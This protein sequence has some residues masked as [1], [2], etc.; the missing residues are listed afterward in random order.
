MHEEEIPFEKYDPELYW[1]DPAPLD[2]PPDIPILSVLLQKSLLRHWPDDPALA[3]FAEL[4]L[5]RLTEI[6][7]SAKGGHFAQRKRHEGADTS[8][9]ARD[10]SMRAHL[11]N[12]LLTTLRLHQLAVQMGNRAAA[13]LGDYGRRLLIAT[14]ILHDYSKMIDDTQLAEAIHAPS[15]DTMPLIRQEISNQAEGLDLFH[16][17]ENGGHTV[18]LDDLIYAIHHTQVKWDTLPAR[19]LDA[20]LSDSRLVRTVLGFS[21]MAD[22]LA[23]GTFL[24]TNTLGRINEILTETLGERPFDLTMHRM[25]QVTGILTAYIQNAALTAMSEHGH[26]PIMFAPNGVIYASP[27]D[28]TFPTIEDIVKQVVESVLA[29]VKYGIQRL[30]R[31]TQ[32]VGIGWGTQGLKTA[33]FV[34][35]FFDLPQIIELVWFALQRRLHAPQRAIATLK[36]YKRLRKGTGLGW[37]DPEDA[38]Q[39]E[40]F[41]DSR[42]EA[43]GDWLA[44]TT[45]ISQPAAEAI[46]TQLGFNYTV[47]KPLIEEAQKGG[48][49][50]WTAWV[51]TEF[52][53]NNPT[54]DPNEVDDL[55]CSQVI[56]VL[57]E[58]LAGVVAPGQLM[59]AVR[60]FSAECLMLTSQKDATTTRFPNELHKYSQN[61]VDRT[62]GTYDTIYNLPDGVEHQQETSLP[63]MPTPYSQRIPLGKGDALGSGWRRGI[64]G[65]GVVNMLLMQAAL[66][67][68][69]QFEER[70]GKMLYIYPAYYFTPETGRALLDLLL[71]LQTFHISDWLRHTENG[72]H[73]NAHKVLHYPNLLDRPP[74]D[75]KPIQALRYPVTIAPTLAQLVLDPGTKKTDTESWINPIFIALILATVIDVKVVVSDSPV[76]LYPSGTAFEE[77]V[78]LDAPHHG[79]AALLGRTFTIDDLITALQR[80]TIALSITVEAYDYK[81]L[82]VIADVARRLADDPANLFY[83]YHRVT[84]KRHSEP[85]VDFARRYLQYAEILSQTARYQQRSTTLNHA[86]ELVKRYRRFYRAEGFRSNTILRPIQDAAAVILQ[87]EPSQSDPSFL[88][89]AIQGKLTQ[90]QTAIMSEQAKGYVPKGSDHQSRQEAMRDFAEYFVYDYFQN[91]LKGRKSQLRGT[92]FNLLRLACDAVYRDLDAAERAQKNTQN[93]ESED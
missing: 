24:E 61:K 28:A 45:T 21:R 30:A 52:I 38:V 2:I 22:L 66:P 93:A 59:K 67:K 13:A 60:Q 58:S 92:Q 70:K 42:A 46:L 43:I 48:V 37:F 47:I 53:R 36:V 91:V 57:R 83:Y 90:I 9:Y 31:T 54:L 79:L 51:A 1:D 40:A 4:V 73:L 74:G 35:D 5:P 23:Y 3:D 86:R 27:S 78:L 39:L 55:I 85:H 88:V 11:L 33:P 19:L 6:V 29:E 56:P 84:E 63:Y 72:L 64:S 68:P 12:G 87:A 50:Y 76:P 15:S 80:M 77:T 41:M 25:S 75:F 44:Y 8:N 18:H 17:I 16:F 14:Y 32:A 7:R 26:T 69:F 49:Q 65:V 71:R 34:E 81:K 82:A 10:Q 62:N 89:D 20:P